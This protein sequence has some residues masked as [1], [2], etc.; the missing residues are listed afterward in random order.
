MRIYL[1]S[2]WSGS[3]KDTAGTI[4][5]KK[6]GCIR[7]AFAD[8]LK[9]I[10]A[11]EF[12]FPVEWAHTEAGK[13][14]LIPAAGKSVRHLLIQRG[15]EI[16]KEQGDPGFF[17]RIVATEI[18]NLVSS[19]SAPEGIVITD[20]RLPVEYETLKTCLT[21]PIV[22]VR[23]RKWGQIASSIAD[24]ETETQ[25][26]TWTFDFTINNLG[27]HLGSL[28]IEISQK[29]IDYLKYINTSTEQV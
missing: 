21:F 14:Q 27:T 15:Q 29:L 19:G 20:W 10:V 24:S 5:Q 2:G 23:I 16:R 1:L 6:Y 26:D 28:E 25:L 4:F 8:V 9:K 3:G 22:K 11:A 18:Q 7:M 13:Q 17:A 12:G